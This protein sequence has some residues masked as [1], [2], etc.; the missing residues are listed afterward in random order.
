KA[1]TRGK[2]ASR[3]RVPRSGRFLREIPKVV[4]SN[5]DREGP[6]LYGT[7]PDGAGDGLAGARFAASPDG[8][9]RPSA[10]FPWLSSQPESGG[11]HPQNQDRARPAYFRRGRKSGW[12]DNRHGGRGLSIEEGRRSTMGLGDGQADWASLKTRKPCDHA[13]F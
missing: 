4:R 8:F 9:A 1:H 10:G 2:R 7:A 3:R 5:G 6:K 13:S 11:S 12:Q